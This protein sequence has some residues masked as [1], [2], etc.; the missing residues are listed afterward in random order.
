MDSDIDDWLQEQEP[1]CMLPECRSAK[2]RFEVLIMSEAGK[3][4]YSYTKRDDA[5]TLMPLCST[6]INYARKTQNETLHSMRTPDSLMINFFTRSPLILIVIHEVDASVDALVLVEQIEAQII[7]ILTA[8]TLRTVFEERPTF[9]LKRLL[10]GSEKYIDSIINITIN[11]TNYAWPWNHAF[12]AVTTTGHAGPDQN[13]SQSSASPN[14]LPNIAHRTLVPVATLHHKIRDAMHSTIMSTVSS[15]SKN[16]VFSL[17]FKVSEVK[18]DVATFEDSAKTENNEAVNEVAASTSENED[19]LESDSMPSNNVAQTESFSLSTIC[20]HHNRHKLK[21][22]DIHVILA[23]LTGSR[24]SL[25][26]VES[27]WMP[28]CL[29]KFNKD[30]YLHAFISYM[31]NKR[32]CIVMLGVDRDEF[33]NCQKA[34]EQIEAKLNATVYDDN[35]EKERVNYRMAPLVHPI[36]LDLQDKLMNNSLSGDE[37]A[38]AQQ[39]IQIYNSK[40]S[41]YH[42]R[43]LQMIWYQTSKQVL[44]W[45]RSP[46]TPISAVLYHITAKMQQ[47][48]L[49]TLWLKLN[50]GSVFLGCHKPNFQLYTQF[51]GTVTTSEATE[52]IKKIINWIKKEEEHFTI[53]E[54]K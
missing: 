42:A 29:P 25:N 13:T 41:M 21:I 19:E 34:K 33:S 18:S 4:I 16:L 5:V 48:N 49:K 12:L 37:L 23:L 22:A 51:D 38:E 24:V 11:R 17:V 20:N 10:Y 35:S 45:Q 28:V 3:P 53:K 47:S 6:L 30:A 46:Q 1:I 31:N 54:Y 43:Q 15:L 44:W 27:L 26:S 2:N 36:L 8:K 40:L 32:N 9:D 7:S 52:V 14:A 39:Q 50:D